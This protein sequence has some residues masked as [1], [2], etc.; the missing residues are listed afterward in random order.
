ML[1]GLIE[2]GFLP[3]ELFN[4]LPLFPEGIL[5]HVITMLQLTLATTVLTGP[6][7]SL[8]NN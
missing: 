8:Q 6:I 2:I 3:N 7:K 1:L 5:T 4:F